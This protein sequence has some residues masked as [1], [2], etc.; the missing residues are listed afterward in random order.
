MSNINPQSPIID[1]QP[2]LVNSICLELL[3]N[4]LV[5]L[6]ISTTE[7]LK[8]QANDIHDQLVK[9]QLK[10]SYTGDISILDSELSSSDDV[11]FRLEQIGYN[12]GLRVSELLNYNNNINQSD[13]LTQP[14]ELL[15]IMKFICR[16]VWKFNY[17]KQIDNLRTNHRGT[18]VLIDNEFKY[19]KYLSSNVNKDEVLLLQRAK[20]WLYLPCGIIKGVLKSYDVDA[21]VTPELTTLPKVSFNIQT[22]I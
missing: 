15:T 6:S 5:P 12:F 4:E 3:L 7:I 9:I 10:D 8:T 16:D 21:L 2:K 1:F 17:G 22:T 14:L 18:F 11:S 20:L 13:L 19:F